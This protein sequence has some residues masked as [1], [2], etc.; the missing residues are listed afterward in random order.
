MTEPDGWEPVR[1]R[2]SRRD[3]TSSGWDTPEDW[4]H[5]FIMTKNKV[6]AARRQ[7]HLKTSGVFKGHQREEEVRELDIW[8]QEVR[9]S[10]PTFPAGKERQSKACAELALPLSCGKSLEVPTRARDPPWRS[11]RA[12]RPSSRPALLGRGGG[13]SWGRATPPPHPASLQGPRE[14]RRPLL[15]LTH[16]WAGPQGQARR[17]P[18]AIWEG[19]SAAPRSVGAFS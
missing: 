2:D 4:R 8:R 11:L 10:S 19:E 5:L 6:P 18:G 14:K 15:S 12:G 7:A 16:A 13:C 17:N 3:G 1:L 9:I